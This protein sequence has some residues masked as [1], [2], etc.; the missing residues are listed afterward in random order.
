[1]L[2]P[3][4]L[5]PYCRKLAEDIC[6]ANPETLKEVHRLID[7]GW[8][9]SLSEGL[10]EER[11]SSNSVNRGIEAETLEE[12]RLQVQSRGRDQNTD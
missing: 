8:E 12:T 10:A 5:L 2:P 4:E 6:S 3:D 9:H 11:S 1:M 7:Y